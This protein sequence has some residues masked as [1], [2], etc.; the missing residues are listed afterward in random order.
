MSLKLRCSQQGPMCTHAHTVWDGQDQIC[1]DCGLVLC[2]DP[3][4]PPLCLPDN[5]RDWDDLE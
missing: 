5:W 2:S 1:T 3:Y 4:H